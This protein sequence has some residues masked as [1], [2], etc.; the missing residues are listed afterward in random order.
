MSGNGARQVIGAVDQRALSS[1]PVVEQETYIPVGVINRGNRLGG[2][3]YPF[4][5]TLVVFAGNDAAC[6]SAF[7]HGLEHIG[8]IGLRSN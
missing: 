6:G 2:L 5:G 7:I 1:P 4:P 3:V 8:S